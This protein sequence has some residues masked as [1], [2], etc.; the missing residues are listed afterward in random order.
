[1]LLYPNVKLL[2]EKTISFSIFFFLLLV[3]LHYQSSSSDEVGGLRS[4]SFS[5]LRFFF[6]SWC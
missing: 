3:R 1:M 4:F 5:M 6:C 2:F